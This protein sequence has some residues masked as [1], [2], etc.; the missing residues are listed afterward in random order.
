MIDVDLCGLRVGEKAPVRIMGVINLS[1]E[2]F[3]KQSIVHP[4]LLIETA[5]QMVQEGADI[6]DIGGRS[7]W[8]LA[9]KITIA[10][11]RRRVMPAI[12]K[13]REAINIPLSIDTMHSQIAQEAIE[14]GADIINDVSGFTCDENMPR[15]AAEHDCP[16]ILMASRRKPGDVV[17]IQDTLDALSNIV[18]KAETS[19]VGGERIILDPAVGRWCERRSTADDLEILHHFER[20]TI[21][22]KPLLA[23]LSRKSFI[24]DILKKPPRQRLYGS[25]AAT[26]IAVYKGAHI[27]RTHD[28]AATV[29]AVRMAEALRPRKTRYVEGDFTLEPLHLTHPQD[30]EYLMKKIGTTEAGS[31]IM[32]HKTTS[33]AYLIENLTATE[34]L[35]IKQ[36]LL[37][38]GGDAALPR[39]AISH[40][41]DNLNIIIFGT[42]LQLSRLADKLRVQARNLPVIAELLTQALSDEEC[43]P[44]KK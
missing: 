36:E 40:E 35:I 43:L 32:K 24:G 10:E 11:E 23:A 17:G 22:G 38:R 28:V 14:L 19:G 41:I 30:S 5:E 16:V 7:T 12:E 15:V 33:R 4:D 6:I 39:E 8:P 34:A 44:H 25:L 21:F 37:A 26:A 42:P 29:D 2:S 13:L 20:F 1:S 27:V 9:P 3:Y 18:Q 31:R